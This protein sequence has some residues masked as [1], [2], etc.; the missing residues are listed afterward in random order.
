MEIKSI[1]QARCLECDGI[2]NLEN[3]GDYYYSICPQTGEEIIE[4]YIIFRCDCGCVEE[5]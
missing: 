2:G 1:T 5:V 3:Y 4:P